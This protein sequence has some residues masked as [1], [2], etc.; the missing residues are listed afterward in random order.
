[1]LVLIRISE[2]YFQKRATSSWIVNE[3]SDDSLNITLSFD[4]IEISISRS[5]NSF[6]FGGGIYATYLTLSL[7]YD[8]DI[9]YI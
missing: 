9:F 5:C 3:G 6:G 1:M 2:V 7:A 4:E 8:Y